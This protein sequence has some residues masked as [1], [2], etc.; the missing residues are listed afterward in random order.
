MALTV[1]LKDR[2]VRAYLNELKLAGYVKP[3][4]A[5]WHVNPNRKPL[6]SYYTLLEQEVRRAQRI[7]KREAKF[8]FR[9]R[10]G[11]YKYDRRD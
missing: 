6:W 9:Y 3:H 7:K 2:E 5:G 10:T 1:Q 11:E 4:R 8:K